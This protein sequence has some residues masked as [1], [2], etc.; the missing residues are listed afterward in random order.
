[1]ISDLGLEEKRKCLANPVTTFIEIYFISQAIWV[2][3]VL[4]ARFWFTSDDPQSIDSFFYLTSL[5]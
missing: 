3:Y 4:R 2:N 1:M 5:L